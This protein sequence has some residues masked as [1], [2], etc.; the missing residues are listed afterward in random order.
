MV[1]FKTG[2]YGNNV[3]QG[4]DSEVSVFNSS[5]IIVREGADSV[6]GSTG[7]WQTFIYM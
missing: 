7:L 6:P 2:E 4:V 5:V 3:C 1:N